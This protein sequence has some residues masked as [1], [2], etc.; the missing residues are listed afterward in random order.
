MARKI[1]HE[2]GN[3]LMDYFIIIIV[4][5]DKLIN[6]DKKFCGRKTGIGIYPL[7]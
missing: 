4:I 6:L 2:R 3:K 5:V 1:I 7:K